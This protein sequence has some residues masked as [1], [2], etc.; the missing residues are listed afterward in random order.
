MTPDC[1]A[2]AGASG[3]QQP[4]AGLG[5][6]GDLLPCL[7]AART[8]QLFACFSLEIVGQSSGEGCVRMMTHSKMEN[9]YEVQRDD[10]R[11]A[12]STVAGM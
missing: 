4:C 1:H 7:S 11:E 2:S 10:M 8:D 5:K 9:S 3:G 6:N 12:P